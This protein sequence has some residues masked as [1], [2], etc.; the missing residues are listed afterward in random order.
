MK[1]YFFLYFTLF[2]SRVFSRTSFV[3]Y[4]P[5]SINV[6]LNGT[7]VR[8][9]G[10]RSIVS[11]VGSLNTA[12]PFGVQ[13]ETFA[14]SNSGQLSSL[15]ATI[16]DTDP[17]GD[18]RTNGEE[19]CD[20]E[21][22]WLPGD[23]DPECA[24]GIELTHPGLLP[25]DTGSTAVDP[26]IQLHG[27]LMIF[28]WVIFA[29]IGV[30]TAVVNKNS[31]NGSKTWF[32]V[33]RIC[34]TATVGLTLGAFYVIYD[35]VGISKVETHVLVGFAVLGL[36][37]FQFLL[38]FIRPKA[39]QL[40][41][42]QGVE[43][44]RKSDIRVAWETV[45]HLFGRLAIVL[46]IFALHTGLI[47]AYTEEGSLVGRA[48]VYIVFL[49]TYGSA[50][51]YR[52]C[53]DKP[54]HGTHLHNNAKFPGNVT[55]INQYPQ[56]YSAQS[57][58]SSHNQLSHISLN[59]KRQKHYSNQHR[60]SSSS[61]AT[62]SNGQNKLVDIQ[63]SNQASKAQRKSRRPKEKTHGQLL[64]RKGE[65]NSRLR[66]EQ[67]RA[68]M[69]TKSQNSR[70]TQI[71]KSKSQ[72]VRVKSRNEKSQVSRKSRIDAKSRKSRTPISELS[73][74]MNSLGKSS[75]TTKTVVDKV[76]TLAPNLSPGYPELPPR[77]KTLAH[78]E[79]GKP[80][81]EVNSNLQSPLLEHIP[82]TS[83]PAMLK[84][85]EQKFPTLPRSSI[86]RFM[87]ELGDVLG[88]GGEQG[89]EQEIDNKRRTNIWDD[90]LQLKET[91]MDEQEL[92]VDERKRESKKVY[93]NNEALEF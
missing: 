77:V 72:K 90:M 64:E 61:L 62:D 48:L 2:L 1:A 7:R 3:E 52:L 26:H 74:P 18:N 41:S 27:T 34:L 83:S 69:K 76:G 55:V 13:V 46:S 79:E 92:G 43:Y 16:C 37:I 42:I 66:R 89:F 50:V 54:S 58:N 51:L 84:T 39:I 23:D 28:A 36:A 85:P 78:K 31:A 86:G 24:E 70:V 38:G 53:F 21:C 32:H 30:V 14:Q 22:T 20:P 56:H 8:G 93:W 88:D 4:V 75:G 40:K 19:L 57:H 33:H 91:E 67:S 80:S 65:E 81:S 11:S 9:L 17:D 60:S 6:F 47:L 5:N 15:W 73:L 10:H 87:S 45:H 29:P 82:E 59:P 63:R 44:A 25:G 71:Q 49:F 35:V 68:V 12:N